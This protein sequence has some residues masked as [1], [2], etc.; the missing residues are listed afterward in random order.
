MAARGNAVSLP[1]MGLS[2]FYNGSDGGLS[3]TWVPI[4]VSLVKG[5]VTQ[6]HFHN[7]YEPPFIH[8]ETGRMTQPFFRVALRGLAVMCTSVWKI[9]FTQYMAA[10][11]LVVTI[12]HPWI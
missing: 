3:Q 12:R 8:L 2:I 9:V 11:M 4:P 10:L 7:L 6:S 1:R 5:Y